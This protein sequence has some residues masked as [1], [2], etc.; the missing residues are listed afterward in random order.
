MV[1]VGP[2]SCMIGLISL[3]VRW[4]ESH[5]NQALTLLDLVLH[6]CVF[7]CITFVEAFMPQF[8]LI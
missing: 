4:H 2:E 3:L 8:D 5:L 6:V 7:S 1:H